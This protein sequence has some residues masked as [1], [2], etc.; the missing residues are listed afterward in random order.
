[1]RI[2]IIGIDD[3]KEPYLSPEVV[4]V[5]LHSVN[6]SGGKRHHEIVKP[7]LPKQHLWIDIIPPM[8]QLIEQ[9]RTFENLVVIASCDPLY[10]GIA[11]TIIKHIPEAEVTVYPAFNSLQSLAHKAILPYQDL[12]EVT[13]T[14]RP[15]LKLD[16][17]VINGEQMI[18][19]LLDKKEHT[20][21]TVAHRLLYYG[22][23]NYIAYIGECLGNDQQEKVSKLSLHE[24]INGQFE[25][26]Y[27][28]ILVKFKERA[29][30]FGIPDN[31][32]A[33]LDGRVNMLT[34]MPIRLT[35]LSLLDLYQKHNFWDIGSCTGSISVEAKLHFPHLQITAFEVRE[36]GEKLLNI[37]SQ[38]FG[39]PGIAFVGGDFRES[40]IDGLQHPDCAFIGGHGGHLKEIVERVWSRLTSYGVLVFNSVSFESQNAFREA[41]DGVGGL[42]DT[43]IR[44]AIDDHNP[45]TIMKAMK[46]DE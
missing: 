5:L 15:W 29:K 13:L 30:P 20:P 43:E 10:N 23:D 39:T 22:Y 2:S 18:G 36:E 40:D 14:G 38:R 1:M 45:I 37:N 46:Q 8:S 21:V 33:L 25:Y 3:C 11:E 4:E 44:M 35:T 9:Y 24:V 7:F 28:M 6:F 42:I 17:A 32:L 12:H 31:A 27:N 16:E 34:K 41:I 19:V 26:P